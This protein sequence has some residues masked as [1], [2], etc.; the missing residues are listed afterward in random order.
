MPLTI[1]DPA[2][3]FTGDTPD[4]PEFAV[5]TLGGRF[6]LF[7]FIPGPAQF[8]AAFTRRFAPPA[9]KPRGLYLRALAH[10]AA[11][12][13]GASLGGRVWK[14]LS[15]K[16]RVASDAPKL[17]LLTCKWADEV[18]AFAVARDGRDRPACF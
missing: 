12:L 7:G 9:G 3:W 18:H 13:G 14:M 15:A 16:L 10:A 17:A 4:N 11:E 1:G 2:P 5:G 8:D 6:V